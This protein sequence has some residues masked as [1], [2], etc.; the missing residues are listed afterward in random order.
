MKWGRLGENV[1]ANFNEFRHFIAECIKFKAYDDDFVYLIKI[2]TDSPL[3]QLIDWCPCPECMP[4]KTVM[5]HH[6]EVD[7]FIWLTLSGNVL[8]NVLF[9]VLET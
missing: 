9:N 2:V 5:T 7:N 1:L 8:V 3:F 6:F 4:I